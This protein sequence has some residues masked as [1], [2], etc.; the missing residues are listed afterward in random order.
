MFLIIFLQSLNLVINNEHDFLNTTNT[1][2]HLIEMQF[3][4]MIIILVS[5]QL[6]I[7]ER[8]EFLIFLSNRR[9]REHCETY[10]ELK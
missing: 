3:I 2:R 6:E 5:L 7:Y 10:N 4:D 9:K 1:S 8:Y